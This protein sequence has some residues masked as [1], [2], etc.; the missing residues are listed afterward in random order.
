[1]TNLNNDIKKH[2]T[3]DNLGNH[4]DI[5][6]KTYEQALKLV[7]GVLQVAGPV[8]DAISVGANTIDLANGNMSVGRY[9]FNT[10]GTGASLYAT[11]AYG[12]PV[13][14]TVGSLVY[15]GD[16]IITAGEEISEA[17]KNH[18]N[19]KI[20]N[21]KWYDFGTMLNEVKNIMTNSIWKW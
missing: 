3:K 19:P 9:S 7:D 16:L 1:M 10:V 13:G 17:K 11:Y 8:A 6:L 4:K 2:I 18:P 14:I 21:S 20:R 5:K 15:L 12:G